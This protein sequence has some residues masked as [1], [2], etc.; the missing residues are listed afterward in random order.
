MG[1]DDVRWFLKQAGNFEEY[2]AL[3]EQLF[4]YIMETDVRD[5]GLEYQVP[6]GFYFFP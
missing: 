2:V 3:N 1:V 6:V 5:Y 4:D